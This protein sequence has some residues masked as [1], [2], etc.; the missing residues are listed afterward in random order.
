MQVSLNNKTLPERSLL[1][2]HSIGFKYLTK[3]KMKYS[4]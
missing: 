3:N 1:K 2:N 4:M